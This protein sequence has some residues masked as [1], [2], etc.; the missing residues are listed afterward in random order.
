MNVCPGV[1]MALSCFGKNDGGYNIYLTMPKTKD[2]VKNFSNYYENTYG[3]KSLL[4]V[5][6]YVS[7][8]DLSTE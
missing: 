2:S 6:T 4:D 7:S 1:N 8:D 3:I 5:N